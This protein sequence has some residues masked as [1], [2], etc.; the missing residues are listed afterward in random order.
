MCERVDVPHRSAFS[1]SPLAAVNNAASNLGSRALPLLPDQLKRQVI[2]R[3]AIT[4]DGNRLDAS[5][6]IMLS[7]WKLMGVQGLTDGDV[8][9]IMRENMRRTL[10]QLNYNPVAVNE[11]TDL[12]IPGTDGEISVRHYLPQQVGRT[13]LMVFYHGGGWVF[14]D[15]DTHD[16]LCR[17]IC[18]GAGIQVL[19]V[20]YRLAPEH[21]APAG[22]DDAY[23]A[24]QWAVTHA[25]ELGADPSR[26]C[27]GGDS[28]GANLAAVIAHQARDDGTR[29]ALQLLLCANTDMRGDT[30]SRKLFADGFLLTRKDIDL[31]VRYY[32]ANSDMNVTDPR[33]SPLLSNNFT[34]LPP[35]IVV[36]AGFD[37]LRD[38]GESYAAAL[39]AAGNIVDLRRFGSMVHPFALLDALGGGCAAAVTEIIS[40]V[41]AHLQYRA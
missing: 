36:T 41:K 32:L 40:A 23:A 1:A 35:A 7:A 2:G 11:V 3:R 21:P 19:S 33:I 38:E 28:A 27:V 13:P 17:L 22:L 6:Q 25:D 5:L 20:D 26:V 15:L 4:I 14:G 29:P 9:S 39:E 34:G 8:P 31:L 18:R 16:R 24:Y 12:A 30:A 37:P 10:S